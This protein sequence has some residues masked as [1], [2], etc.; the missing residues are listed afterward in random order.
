MMNQEAKL[1]LHNNN[2]F[3]GRLIAIVLC[4]LWVYAAP[5]FKSET[6][7][8]SY[9]FYFICLLLEAFHSVTI[10][11]SYI[12]V[13]YFFSQISDKNF[14]GT[15]LTFLNTV[16]NLARSFTSTGTLYMANF[17]SYKYCHFPTSSN[18]ATV[19]AN[20]YCSSDSESKVNT[21]LSTI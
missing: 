18:N 12:P 9:T 11:S 13:M 15:Y 1:Y 17:L 21:H 2:Y 10:Y 19:D 20:N 5:Y 6:N 8:F 4:A 7:E 3:V 14:G 16:S